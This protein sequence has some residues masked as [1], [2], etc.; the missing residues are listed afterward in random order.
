MKSK[1]EIFVTLSNF[2][3]PQVKQSVVINNKH[4]ILGLPEELSNY[5]R[6][7]HFHR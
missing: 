5:L 4:G 2:L 7:K 3:S 6:L 1:I